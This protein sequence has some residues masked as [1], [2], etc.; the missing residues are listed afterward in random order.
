MCF[1]ITIKCWQISLI[2]YKI[3]EV[4]LEL[5]KIK[6]TEFEKHSLYMLSLKI[7]NL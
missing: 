5:V 6:Y 3:N 4:T 1:L 7:I 2:F